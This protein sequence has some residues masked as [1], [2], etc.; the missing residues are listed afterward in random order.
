MV[1]KSQSFRRARRP[2]QKAERR[3]QLLDAA[4]ALLDEEGLDAVTLSAIA[5]R[6]AIAKSATYT[7]FESRE[8]ILIQLLLDD[9]TGYVDDIEKALV[10]T[11]GENDAGA[12]AET[13]TDAYLARPR[14]C[15]LAS[16]VSSVL[17]QN[18]SEQSVLEFKRA[19]LALGLRMAYVIHAALPNLP[20][21]RCMW[22]LRPI[23]AL[24]AG[25]WPMAN[26]PENVARALERPELAPHVIDARED[27]RRTFESLLLGE[28]SRS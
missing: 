10:P 9:W 22:V 3:R 4:A 15:V 5:R 20:F 23:A 16:V 26:P 12:V 19:T 14:F 1:D 11:L 27:L 18:V 2:E 13:M 24:V 17:E 25:I 21:E 6:A 28:L 7:Y 8:A